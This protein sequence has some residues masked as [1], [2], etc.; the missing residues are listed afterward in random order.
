MTTPTFNTKAPTTPAPKFKPPTKSGWDLAVKGRGSM[1]N[2]WQE[3]P[4]ATNTAPADVQGGAYQAIQGAWGMPSGN[5]QQFTNFSASPA[6]GQ[7]GP[8]Q[9]QGSDWARD[10]SLTGADPNA[11]QSQG[12]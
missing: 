9:A 3:A 11:A 10:Y 12:A 2:S 8:P 1:M 7:G 6:P 4:T 5:T